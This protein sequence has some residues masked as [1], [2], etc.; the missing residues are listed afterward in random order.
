[1]CDLLLL[2]ACITSGCQYRIIQIVRG[3]ILSQFSQISLQ[4]R[5][6]SSEFFLIIRPSPW[7]CAVNNS[8]APNKN[9]THGWNISRKMPHYVISRFTNCDSI[10]ISWITWLIFTYKSLAKDGC[11]II[12]IDMETLNATGLFEFFH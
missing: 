1:M 5:K 6:F 4:S 2:Y 3:G 11:P 9:Q 7:N 12:L 10:S 8:T